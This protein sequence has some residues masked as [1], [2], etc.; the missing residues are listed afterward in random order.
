MQLT[1]RLTG[2]GSPYR[3]EAFARFM[4]SALVLANVLTGHEPGRDAFHRV[5]I[6]SGQVRDAV[7]CVPTGVDGRFMGSILSPGRSCGALM[8]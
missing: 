8:S 2:D 3:P 7:E 4:G 1:H 5:P 6:F